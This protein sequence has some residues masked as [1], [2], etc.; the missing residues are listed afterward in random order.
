VRNASRALQSTM[1]VRLLLG[2]LTEFVLRFDRVLWLHENI[3]ALRVAPCRD[4]ASP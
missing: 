3:A 4:S 1:Q 2:R